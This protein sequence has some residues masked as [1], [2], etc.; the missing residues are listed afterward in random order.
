MNSKYDA[1]IIGGGIAGLTAA[2]ELEKQHQK[3]LILE[4]TDRVGGRV[5]T[6]LVDGFLLDHGFQ[7]Y[8]TA[9][10]EGQKL[11]NHE[12]L[13]FKTFYSGALCYNAQS[14]FTVSDVKRYPSS[15]FQMA[16]SPVGSV[17]DKLK[18]ARLN[19]LLS[20]EEIKDIFEKPEQTTLSYLK[21][22]GYGDRIIERFFKP[23]YSGIF[24]DK[25]LETSSRMFE[26]VFKM[27]ALGEAALPSEGMEAIPK[28]LKAGLQTTDFNFNAEVGHIEQ[29]RV[30]LKSGEYIEAPQI[31]IATKPDE[32]VP[33]LDSS[34][35]WRASSTYYFSADAS[36]LNQNVIALNSQKSKL[37]NH[38]TVISDT[39][40]SYAPKGKH[41]VS[42]SLEDMPLS[43][44]I[45]TSEMIK[46]ELARSFGS[47]VRHWK[48]L[49]NYDIH[50]SLPTQLDFKSE[51][52]ISETKL[53]DGLYLAGDQMLNGSINAAMTSGR[54]AATAMAH[55]FKNIIQ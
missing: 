50:E 13:H 23:F 1:I 18:L 52:S 38:F 26:F 41:L 14:R 8:L 27:F 28:Q 55:N 10:P 30:Q 54:L 45:I 5:K 49:K 33:Q 44:S 42:V 24:F 2:L 48:F 11:L 32:M 4:K 46:E 20:V 29:Q 12:E 53:R 7:V 3:V 37:V 6:D 51:I 9:Y 36:L 31:L 16:F 17:S 15:F 34:I 19:N 21:D 22:K 43:S 25:K 35:Q 40:K 47:E 39:A